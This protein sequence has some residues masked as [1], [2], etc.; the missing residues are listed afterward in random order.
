MAQ[1]ETPPSKYS[2]DT[3][4]FDFQQKSARFIA[5]PHD[6]TKGENPLLFPPDSDSLGYFT[7]AIAFP[8]QEYF[9]VADQ[10]KS[11]DGSDRHFSI[12]LHGGK[13]SMSGEGSFRLWTYGRDRYGSPAKFG[14]WVFSNGADFADHIGEVAYIKDDY[15]PHGY[16][17]VSQTG[18]EVNFMQVLIP[19]SITSPL[20]IVTDLSD[21]RRVGGT[22][23]MNGNLDTYVMQQ[24]N[25]TVAL[26][27]VESDGTFA[28]V[29]SNGLV[30]QYAARE[31]ASLH[32]QGARLFESS[33][34]ITLA[35]NIRD[36]NRHEGKVSSDADEYS[37]SLAVPAG[38]KVQ[39]VIVNQ[40]PAAFTENEGFVT[41]HAL[42]GDSDIVIEYAD[43]DTP[44]TTAPGAVDD[45]AASNPGVSF[46]TLTW[47]APGNDGDQ[48]TAAYY[49]LRYHT[50]PI[51]E[52]NWHDARQVTGEPLPEPAGTRQS[53][54]VAGL[55]S[56]TTYYF[57]L[58]AGDA[59]LNLSGLSNV[60]VITTLDAD[61]ATPPATIMDLEA[62]ET[63]TD[64]VTLQWTAPGDDGYD[65]I[66][67]AY[68]VRYSTRPITDEN[69][70]E[71][72][73]ASGAP[74]P[75][76]A[77]SAQRMTI[78][79]LKPGR[80]YF[81]AMRTSD[82]A[83]NVSGLSNLVFAALPDDAQIAAKLPIVAVQASSHDGNIPENV[84]DGDFSTRWSAQSMGPLGDRTA[85]YIE[86]DLGAIRNASYMK[87]AYYSGDVRKSYLDLQVS[88]DGTN[89]TNVLVNGET[90][91][92]TADFETYELG[93]VP[94]RY[95][96]LL[97]YGNHSSGWNSITEVEIYGS[98]ASLPDV[99]VGTPALLDGE[100]NVLD[101]L[102]PSGELSVQ[103][104]VTNNRDE[105]QKVTIIIGLYN[106]DDRLAHAAVITDH[107]AAW[108]T[109]HLAASMNVPDSTDGY[110]VKLFVW[111]DLTGMQ[112]KSPA[113]RL[114]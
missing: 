113:I 107:V 44:D 70:D 87:I 34:P 21:N 79:G 75:A 91:G 69:W 90:S 55:R 37:L 105:A 72:I 74:E 52:A 31:A 89:W 47:T 3:D 4:F 64:A 83:G 28:Y 10:L 50:E 35:M 7:R 93:D 30:Q 84:I 102:P 71:A 54:E 56:G 6:T 101:A 29:R 81:I 94:A 51:T 15:T 8:G 61:D 68:E 67:A 96:R 85:E 108:E 1:N 12:Y 104:P 40:A 57:A 5:I 48:G 77:G 45:L 76:A 17:Q 36:R 41:L 103:V 100:G 22:V 114:P 66:A 26:G 112:A 9:V 110:Y 88:V 95:V 33:E 63:T 86:F 42:S 38:Q 18:S 59:S 16:L 27:D 58:R 111:D 60:A 82:E 46:V 98:T 24:G 92:M 99:T 25:K 39:A 49:D 2:I 97:G 11:K 14:A 73:Q 32:Y 78:D 65:D 13:G 106:P 62:V 20:P 53:M 43:G 19:M 80:T 23:A 109:D